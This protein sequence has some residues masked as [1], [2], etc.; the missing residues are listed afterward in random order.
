M[1]NYELTP[2][3]GGNTNRHESPHRSVV[4][5]EMV[6]TV[7]TS[8]FEKTKT[9]DWKKIEITATQCTNF[10]TNKTFLP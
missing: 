7:N 9:H 1:D 8:L 4:T 10:I 6:K 5:T 3:Q 2:F